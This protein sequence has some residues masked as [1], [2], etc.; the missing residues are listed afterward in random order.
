MGKLDSPRVVRAKNAAGL[1]ARPS[2]AKAVMHYG[3]RNAG[4]SAACRMRTSRSLDA[5]CAT[6]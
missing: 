4:R 2:V 5:E 6:S 3:G 1:G